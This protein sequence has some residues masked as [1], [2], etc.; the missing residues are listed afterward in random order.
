MGPLCPVGGSQPVEGWPGRLRPTTFWRF[1]GT[2][3]VLLIGVP[4]A[5]FVFKLLIIFFVRFPYRLVRWSFAGDGRDGATV[6]DVW[7]GRWTPLDGF[8]P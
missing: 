3:L 8:M 6:G 1:V 4:I 7:M 5:W 2:A